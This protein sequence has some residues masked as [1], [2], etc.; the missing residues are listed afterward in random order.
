MTPTYT[1]ISFAALATAL[2]F[3]SPAHA[4]GKAD[5]AH[6]AIAAAQAKIDAANK[7]GATGE[8]PRLQAE[9]AAM[10]RKAREEVESGKKDE[11]IADANRAAQLADTAL[12]E[13]QHAKAVDQRAAMTDAN[14]T[15]ASAQADAAAANERAAAAER[16]ATA[17]AMEAE[18]ARNTPAP[19]PV[20]F[21]TPPAPVA[22]PTTTTTVSTETAERPA[23]V[24]ATKHVVRKRVVHHV[25]HRKP[26]PRAIVAKTTT[27]VKTEAN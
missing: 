20:V 24:V 21:V 19:A 9:A 16:A 1:K 4:Q 8:V 18:R 15:A 26:A 5:R 17:S 7:I 11:A 10:L 12:G 14:R 3:A 22:A 27:T 2:A 23:V 13:T 6:A 25:A